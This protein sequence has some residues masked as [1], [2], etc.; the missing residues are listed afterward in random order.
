MT[1]LPPEL[2]PLLDDGLPNLVYKYP[3]SWGGYGV[4]FMRVRDQDQAIAIARQLDREEGNNPPGLFQPFVCSRFLPG[5]RIYDVR[6][7]MLVTPVGIRRTLTLRRES[8]QAI[9]KETNDGLFT[10][11]GVFTS[12]METGGTGTPLPP[13]EEEGIGPAA[14][15]VSEAL[16]RLLSRGFETVG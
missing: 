7:E 13:D 6:C 5:R 1:R 3:G 2:P 12:N 15:A 16:V 9:P 8:T 10:S 11:K 4:Y 14:V